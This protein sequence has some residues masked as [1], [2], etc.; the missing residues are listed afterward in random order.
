MTSR[1]IKHHPWYDPMWQ[2]QRQSEQLEQRAD[3][4]LQRDRKQ[5]RQASMPPLEIGAPIPAAP[6]KWR[7]LADLKDVLRSRE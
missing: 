7:P 6:S 1:P 3:E 2:Q 4:I 5:Q